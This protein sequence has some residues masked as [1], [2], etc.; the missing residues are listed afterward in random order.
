MTS[1]FGMAL[2]AGLLY[3]MGH[4]KIGYWF[5]DV[6][7]QPLFIGMIFGLVAGDLKTGLLLGGTI[8]LV[9]LGMIMPGGN[10]PSDPALASVIA[11]PIALN[12]GLTAEQAVVLAV[13]F[14]VL[15][16]FIDQ[17]R[18]TMNAMF[19]HRADKLAESGNG[20]GIFREGVIYPIIQGF[21]LR[22]PIVFLV[23]LFGSDVVNTV[24]D[25]LPEWI[26]HGLEVAGGL[27]PALGFAIVVYTIGKRS[28]LP[29]FIIGYF[30][31]VYLELNTMAAAVFG[32]CI[33]ILVVSSRKVESEGA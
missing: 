16:V 20:S 5:Y 21:V 23:T 12:T 2:T 26:M 14:G 7:G 19:I 25:F 9:Y 4:C 10:I 18:R 30:S 22:F 29:Y 17:I 3:F 13:P 33:A 28:I 6:F 15:G 27:L 1:N 8:Q 31:V 32:L 11:I 24:M